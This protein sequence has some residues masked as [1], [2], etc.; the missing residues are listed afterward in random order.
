MAEGNAM[1]I[2]CFHDRRS[3]KRLELLISVIILL[4]LKLTTVELQELQNCTR[5]KMHSIPVPDSACIHSLVMYVALLH[6]LVSF[7]CTNVF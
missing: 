1:I 3:F 7:S 5:K 4:E 6:T 2:A